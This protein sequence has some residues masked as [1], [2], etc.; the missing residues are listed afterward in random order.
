MRDR[1]KIRYDGEYFERGRVDLRKRLAF[2]P[3]APFVHAGMSVLR[4]IGRVVQLYDAAGE[5]VEQTVIELLT[6]LDHWR[7]NF[8]RGAVASQEL[9]VMAPALLPLFG[10]LRLP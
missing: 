2:L 10:R 6:E 8:E 1:G 9:R 5:G 7:A 4:H 3:D